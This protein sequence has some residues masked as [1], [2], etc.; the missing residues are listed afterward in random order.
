MAIM[1]SLK[2]ASLFPSLP[3][4]SPFSFC[5]IIAE[6]GLF[7]Q[8]RCFLGEGCLLRPTG[9]LIISHFHMQLS[10]N[11]T[12]WPEPRSSARPHPGEL[13]PSG[14]IGST[15]S[16]SASHPREGGLASR[17]QLSLHGLA[18]GVLLRAQGQRVSPTT[19]VHFQRLRGSQEPLP[20]RPY[21]RQH[22]VPAP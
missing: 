4:Q 10:Q 21:P 11:L 8:Q 14:R 3:Q 20:L 19:R 9:R 17:D 22:A 16:T 7:S 1:V 18:A 13:A 2:Q 12:T 5:D 15:A 6:L